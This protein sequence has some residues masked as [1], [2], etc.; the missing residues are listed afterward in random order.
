MSI[1]SYVHMLI[2]L[3]VVAACSAGSVSGEIEPGADAA[4]A[5]SADAGRRPDAAPDTPDAVPDAAAGAPDA[6][7]SCAVWGAPGTC[8]TV[9]E[10]AALGNHTAYAGYCPGPSD[11]EC[12]IVTPSTAN[13]PPIPDG[14]K[15]MKQ[16]QVTT[17]MTQWAVDILHDPV[18]YPMFATTTRMFGDQLVL[19]RVEWHPPDFQN[20]VVH[21]G[22]TLYVPI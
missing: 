1:R 2:C 21:R 11:I 4:A 16:S 20:G 22:V 15:L 9:S 14:Y 17:E 5:A 3:S 12:C 18:T 10:C 13:N 7:G 6:M 8:I 19:A